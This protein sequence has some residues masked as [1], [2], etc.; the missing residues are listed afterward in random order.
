MLRVNHFPLRGDLR[1]A[2]SCY[3]HSNAR[4]YCGYLRSAGYSATEEAGQVI[5][6]HAEG[7]EPDDRRKPIS[8]D[9]LSVGSPPE[10]YGRGINAHIDHLLRRAGF[11]RVGPRECR[12][13]ISPSDH[14]RS[15][16]IEE[17]GPSLPS[18][19]AHA[20]LRWTWELEWWEGAPWLV[21]LAGRCFLTAQEPRFPAL[22]R[23]LRLRLS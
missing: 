19:N 12:E 9:I 20:H 15:L 16:V 21:P 5:V 3:R 2:R 18:L 4:G 11:V 17:R 7:T 6:Y 13:Y 22:T 8:R 14:V 10:Q 23:W 1:V